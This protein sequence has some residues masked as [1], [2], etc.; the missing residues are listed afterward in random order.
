MVTAESWRGTIS[1]YS[2]GGDQIAI[3]SRVFTLDRPRKRSRPPPAEF[4][5]CSLV[6]SQ[7]AAA[8]SLA[9]QAIFP[10]A[11]QATASQIDASGRESMYADHFRRTNDEGCPMEKGAATDAGPT[12]SVARPHTQCESS[13]CRASAHAHALIRL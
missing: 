9:S 3:G 1:I 7:S 8:Q 4:V 13:H 12:T 2:I 10:C 11:R 5:G 6:L